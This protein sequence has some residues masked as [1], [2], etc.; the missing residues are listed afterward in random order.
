MRKGEVSFLGTTHL[1]RRNTDVGMER[2]KTVQVRS[3][4]TKID[5]IHF[6]R[7]FSLQYCHIKYNNSG[8]KRQQIVELF[9]WRY[10]ARSC[11]LN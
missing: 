8:A 11:G 6:E 10:L 3:E 5:T 9:K 7:G 1:S 4:I 2:Q